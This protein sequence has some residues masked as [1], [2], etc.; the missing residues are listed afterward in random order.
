M[1]LGTRPCA[2]W[3]RGWRGQPGSIMR[4]LKCQAE[5]LG[6][7]PESTGNQAKVLRRS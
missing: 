3:S 4:N 5:E 7:Y 2:T 1:C 6:L